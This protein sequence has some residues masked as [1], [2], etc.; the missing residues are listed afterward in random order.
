VRESGTAASNLVT[1]DIR[2]LPWVRA[3]LADYVYRFEALAPFYAGDPARAEA[4]R[5]AVSRTRAHPRPRQ[6]LADVLGA[7]L[8]RR[9]APPEA[10]EAAARLARPETVAVVTG[11]QA[12]VLG[13]PLFTLLKALTAI[14]LARRL[15]REHGIAAVPVFWID[16]EDHDWDEVAGTVVLDANDELRSLR[17]PS[18][19]HANEVP[20]ATVTLDAGVTRLLEELQASLPPTEFS[21]ELLASLAEAYRPGLGMADAFGRWL[22]SLLGSRGLVVYDCADPAAKPLAAPVFVRELS[23][24]GRTWALALA[25]GASLEARGYHAQVTSHADGVALF[26]LDGARRAIHRDDNTLTAGERQWTPE[27]IRREAEAHPERF[28]PNVLLRPIVQDTLFPTVAYVGGPSELAYL[29]QLRQVYAHF[30]VPMPLVVPRATATLLDPAAARFLA[31]Y[32]VPLTALQPQDEAELNRL[33]EA[34]LPP[35]LEEALQ[36]AARTIEG[37]MAAVIA[38]V[39]GVDP[40]LEGAARSTLGRMTHDLRTLHQKVIHAAKRRHDTL[41]RQ[42]VRTR[43]LVFPHG[44]P[45]ERTLGF[46]WFLN[47]YGPALVDVLERELPGE[48]G[49]HAVLTP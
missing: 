43:A 17:L 30:G 47:R 6:A 7:Q 10:R 13:G 32:D 23:E 25:A 22:E 3:L 5:E 16:A 38:A 21:N 49:V 33:L 8:A 24:I 34:Q 41:R 29:G 9:G 14:R 15:E 20:V 42:F 31:R 19:P 40:T 11:Q 28:S 44:H 36:D 37:K 2:R 45:Q 26:Y 27:A 12:G 1:I 46:V 18:P 35:S 39:P 4:W 48:A